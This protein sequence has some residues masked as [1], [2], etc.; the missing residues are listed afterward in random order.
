MSEHDDTLRQAL[1][2]NARL[3]SERERSLHETASA[4]FAGRL[5]LAERIYWIYA[6]VCVALGVAAI[7]AFAQSRDTKILIGCAVV[8]LVIYE[9]T[10]LMKLWYAAAGLKMSVLKDVRLLRLEVARLATAVGVKETIEPQA[11]Y[12]PLRGASPW[13][14]RLWILACVIVAIAVSTW[15]RLEFGRATGELSADTLVMLNG[16]GS[17]TSTSQIEQTAGD[18]PPKTFTF[19]APKDW[20]VRFVDPL[21]RDMPAEVT[22]TG[23]HNRYEVKLSEAALVDGK[24]RHTRI[25]HIAQAATPGKRVWSH[26]GDVLYS[27]ETNHICIT[28]YLPP[29]ARLESAHP[30]P[31]LQFDQD[32][33]TAIRFEAS[34][35]RNE[36]FVYTVRYRLESK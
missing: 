17:A 4:E 29:G 3:R 22:S 25:E 12:E 31:A 7:N 28:V 1:E 19:H 9:T 14:R 32:G 20:R 23:T 10:V 34:R 13:E 27:V 36:K 26:S 35:P 33:R 16:D 24:L 18:H 2:E 5:R 15:T 11:A 21:G 30:T 6:L 8:M